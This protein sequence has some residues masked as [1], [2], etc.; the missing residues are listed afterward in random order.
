M[1]ARF[2]LITA[3]AAAVLAASPWVAN[4]APVT[5]VV[6]RSL[7][8]ATPVRTESTLRVDGATS[9][10]LG[11]AMDVTVR[12]IDGSLPTALGSCE[13]VRVTGVVTVRPGRVVTV[14]TRGEACAHIV[15]GSLTANAGFV[16]RNVDYRGFGRCRPRLLGEG[17][18]AVAQ[19]QLGG[20]A[21]F[22]GTFRW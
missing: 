20:Q 11:G 5:E 4:A 1:L 21:S 22:S 9:G 3:S 17:L 13:K 12:A 16:R 6:D 2:G 15:D 19:S 14:R 7:F 8:D 18:I 10:P